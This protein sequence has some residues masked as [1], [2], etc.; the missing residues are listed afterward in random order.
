MGNIQQASEALASDL[1]AGNGTASDQSALQTAAASL[2]ADAQAGEADPAP[3]CIHNL[4]ADESAALNDASKAA[5]NCQNAVSELGSGNDSVAVGDIEA[6]T[7]EI[8]ASGN[9]FQAATTDVKTWESG[10]A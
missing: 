7:Q 4:R 5:I 8:T 6:A 10:T 2:Q 3:M 1:D 9:K